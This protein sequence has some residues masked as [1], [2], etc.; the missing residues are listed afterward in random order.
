MGVGLSEVDLYTKSGRTLEIAHQLAYIFIFNF[1]LRCQFGFIHSHIS[2]IHIIPV[3]HN[4][5][6]LGQLAS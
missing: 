4:K 1:H 6:Q 2:P 5:L 3:S